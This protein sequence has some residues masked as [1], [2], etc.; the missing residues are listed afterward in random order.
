[1][2][3]NIRTVCELNK[4]ECKVTITIINDHFL[5]QTS[6]GLDILFLRLYSSY[7]VGTRTDMGGLG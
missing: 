5:F 1:M 7:L 6:T 4:L 2:L 3:E